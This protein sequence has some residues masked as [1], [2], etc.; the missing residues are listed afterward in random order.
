MKEKEGKRRR[1]RSLRTRACVLVVAQIS[2][3]ECLSYSFTARPRPGRPPPSTYHYHHRNPNVFQVALP[4][5][6]ECSGWLAGEGGGEGTVTVP[7][8]LPERRGFRG[9]EGHSRL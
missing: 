1:E 5:G 4:S 2:R 8:D 9:G 6:R 3:G 7:C